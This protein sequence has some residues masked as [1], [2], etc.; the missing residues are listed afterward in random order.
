MPAFML[1][2][3]HMKKEII[4]IDV[5]CYR[6]I[7]VLALAEKLKLFKTVD[8][9]VIADPVSENIP[10]CTR[11]HVSIYPWLVKIIRWIVA[12]SLDEEGMERV[13]RLIRR[14]LVK[15]DDL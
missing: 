5:F 7:K 6:Q 2:Y 3:L 1:D 11:G 15:E 9:M 13:Q 4:Q 14:N 10:C 12:Y 8:V